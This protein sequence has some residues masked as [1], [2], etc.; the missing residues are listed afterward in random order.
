MAQALRRYLGVSIVGNL[1][2]EICSCRSTLHTLDDR[3]TQT[4]GLR[5]CRQRAQFTWALNQYNLKKEDPHESEVRSCKR[6]RG[7]DK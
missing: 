5:G 4:A 3:H 7:P 6:L 1:V 2:W